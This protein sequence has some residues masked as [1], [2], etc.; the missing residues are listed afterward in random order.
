MAIAKPLPRAPLAKPE[1]PKLK[2]GRSLM[3]LATHG[4]IDL[5]PPPPVSQSRHS[6]H[7]RHSEHRHHKQVSETSVYDQCL[8]EAMKLKT[9]ILVEHR[10]RPTRF[11]LSVMKRVVIPPVAIPKKLAVR[12]GSRD[13][14][15]G[16]RVPFTKAMWEKQKRIYS[17][18][19]RLPVIHESR[20]Q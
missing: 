7:K 1:A 2:R 5:T 8:H 4:G 3:F 13:L 19:H 20:Q 12:R 15:S 6:K 10:E 17:K 9:R 16:K 11:S 14:V 18:T